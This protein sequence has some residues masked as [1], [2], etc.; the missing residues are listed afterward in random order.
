ML[1]YLTRN[2]V[3]QLRRLNSICIINVT[4]GLANSVQTVLRDVTRWRI[5]GFP[6]PVKL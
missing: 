4:N 2:G 1:C 5:E 3:K 6:T